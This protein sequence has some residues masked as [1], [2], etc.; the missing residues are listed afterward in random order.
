M[1]FA[2]G[3]ETRAILE[4]E[5]EFGKRRRGEIEARSPERTEIVVGSDDVI[6]FEESR[7]DLTVSGSANGIN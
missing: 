4:D 7:S 1:A 3:A 6:T 5:G 2:Y